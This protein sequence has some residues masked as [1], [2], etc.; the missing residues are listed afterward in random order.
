MGSQSFASVIKE[1]NLDSTAEITKIYLSS[2]TVACDA[3][4]GT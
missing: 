3:T 2:V 1:T 4:D